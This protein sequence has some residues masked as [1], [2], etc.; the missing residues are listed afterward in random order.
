MEHSL[1]TALAGTW[2]GRGA[3]SYPTIADFD[4]TE[5]LLIDPVPGRSLAYWRSRS[6]DGRTGEPRH[7]E[8]GFLRITAEGV[9]LVVAHSFGLVEIATGSAAELELAMVSSVVW[10]SA[11]AKSVDRV[12][13]V[14]RLA[15]DRLEYRLS[16]AA[17]GIPLTHHLA[18]TLTR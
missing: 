1:L 3:G 11:T 4:Y 18:A 9:E 12:E 6:A 14:Y 7:A 2:R 17:V 13:R 10:P 15:G 5:E 8:S 16:M